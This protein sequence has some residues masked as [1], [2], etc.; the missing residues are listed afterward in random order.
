MFREHV[1]SDQC[2]DNAIVLASGVKVTCSR[3]E[4]PVAQLSYLGRSTRLPI[5]RNADFH[6][7]RSLPGVVI[8]IDRYASNEDRLLA[9][10]LAAPEAKMVEVAHPDGGT[11]G[12]LHYTIVSMAANA[13]TVTEDQWAGDSPD[14]TRTLRILLTS[15]F[16]Q[17]V[18]TPWTAK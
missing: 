7:H 16:G 14:R 2:V 18:A 8:V 12:H 13:V 1:G 17:T 10:D 9:V 6:G 15:S 11:Y 3:D 5:M 4:V